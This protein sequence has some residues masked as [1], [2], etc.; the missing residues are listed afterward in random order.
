M[1]GYASISSPFPNYNATPRPATS[2][3]LGNIHENESNIH[4]TAQHNHSSALALALS[5]PSSASPPRLLSTPFP[6][7]ALAPL[8]LS[9]NGTSL[10]TSPSSN[11]TPKSPR[12]AT[13]RFHRA[14][15]TSSAVTM[16]PVSV[17]CQVMSGRE[18][19]VEGRWIQMLTSALLG[20]ASSLTGAKER[21][22]WPP[23]RLMLPEVRM[24][25]YFG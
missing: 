4:I 18:A 7:F 3:V 13:A 1:A 11:K 9:P 22:G 5:E 25:W 17:R 19:R 15:G 24:R 6:F 2:P 23:A 16:A 10:R 21:K 14:W 12:R 20:E 8:P